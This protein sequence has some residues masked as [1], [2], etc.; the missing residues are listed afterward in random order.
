MGSGR[1]TAKLDYASWYKFNNAQ[2]AHAN[3]LESVWG[4]SALMLVGGLFDAKVFAG[5]GAVYFV[6]R[7]L[8]ATGYKSSQG[9]KGREAGA[10]LGA[11]S[12]FG[13]IGYSFKVGYDLIKEAK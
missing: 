4:V 3:F 6:A 13:M 12:T 5:L 7:I 9:P 8:Y 1:Y 11:L 2:R 10:I